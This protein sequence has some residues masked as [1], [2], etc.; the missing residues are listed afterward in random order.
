MCVGGGRRGL[1][2]GEDGGGDLGKKNVRNN[3]HNRQREISN[4]A[5]LRPRA[6]RYL[7]NACMPLPSYLRSLTFPPSHPVKNAKKEALKILLGT[8]CAGCAY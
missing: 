8:P 3:Q 1:K 7:G 2:D 6:K 5:C 4:M